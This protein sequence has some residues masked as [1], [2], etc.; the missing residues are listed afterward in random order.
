[1]FAVEGMGARVAMLELAAGPPHLLLAD[2][3]EGD[4][5]ILI[6]RV[7]NLQKAMKELAGRGWQRGLTIEI[8]PGPVC[9]FTTPGGHRL[10]LFEAA[11]P[12]VL[13][14]F[15]GRKDF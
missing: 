2:H 7:A 6:Y 10:A 8:P 14:H 1:M 12:E 4:R 11:R 3:V 15:E 5:P 9:S 13:Q